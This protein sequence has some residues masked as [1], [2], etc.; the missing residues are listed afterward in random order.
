[1]SAVLSRSGAGGVCRRWADPAAGPAGAGLA[2]GLPDFAVI[3][4]AKRL[5][6]P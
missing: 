6:V 4:A 3:G 1:M 2:G 5:S